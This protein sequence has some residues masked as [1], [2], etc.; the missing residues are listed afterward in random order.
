MWQSGNVTWAEAIVHFPFMISLDKIGV[1]SQHSGQYNEADSVRVET[2]NNG[3]YNQEL[4]ADLTD[5]DQYF[6]FADV[7]DSV[8]RFSFRSGQGGAVTI[9]G[10]E[11][12]YKDEAV[13]PP[14]VP[15]TIQNPQL[16]LL[17]KRPTLLYPE[18]DTITTLPPINLIWM[19]NQSTGYRLQIDIS[20]DFCSPLV[21]TVLNVNSFG[22][23]IPFIY[24][25]YYWRIKGL[26]AIGQSFGEWSEIWD[27]YSDIFQ[28]VKDRE[29]E[30]EI[31]MYPNPVRDKLFLNYNSAESI[32]CISLFNSMGRE[33]YRS[34]FHDSLNYIDT[35]MFSSGV[36]FVRV[37]FE[38]GHSFLKKIIIM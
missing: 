11:L 19:G 32:E 6:S 38:K 9:R 10:L 17:P 3:N 5:V 36:Y 1:H 14:C 22:Y 4:L 21:D 29:T 2:Y 30:K 15:Y 7:T 27:F 34:N 23:Q 37:N 35:K 13:F 18:K 16:N 33:V 8:W 12:F 28:E 26:N 25:K 20:E 31:L 24:S